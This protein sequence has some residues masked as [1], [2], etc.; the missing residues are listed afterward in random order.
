[1]SEQGQHGSGCGHAAGTG[2]AIDPHGLARAKLG[3]PVGLIYS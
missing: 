3:Q 1:M 2:D